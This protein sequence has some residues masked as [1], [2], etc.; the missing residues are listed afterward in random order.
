MKTIVFGVSAFI[1]LLIAMYYRKQQTIKKKI[2]LEYMERPQLNVVPENVTSHLIQTLEKLSRTFDSRIE[3]EMRKYRLLLNS[4]ERNETTYPLAT[5]YQLQLP[6]TIYGMEKITLEKAVFPMSLDLINSHSQKLNMTIVWPTGPTTDT[7]TMLIPVGNYNITDLAAAIQ[8]A[9]DAAAA[10]ASGGTW[11]VTIDP[12]TLLLSI[13]IDTGPGGDTTATIEIN[14]TSDTYLL[15]ILGLESV[16]IDSQT[17]PVAVS[18]TVA[19]TG[20]ASVNVA[21]P[22]NLLIYLDN[23]SYDFNS[24]RIMKSSPSNGLGTSSDERCFANFDMP[25]GTTL[26]S[27]VASAGSVNGAAILVAGSSGESGFGTY[28]VTKDTTNAYYK[29]YEGPIPSVRFIN[30]KI[31]QVI[32]GGGTPVIPD[33]NGSNHSMEFEMKARVDKM[34]ATFK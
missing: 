26:R 13:K 23:K 31:R 22:C 33:F 2:S 28:V 6:E 30:V 11:D 9:M 16:A 27:G 10:A 29:A 20:T 8:T 14:D 17:T 12:T 15:A 5:D 34:S 1:T 24:L 19:L 18:T 32:P 7:Y 21:F 3:P 25:S 4:G